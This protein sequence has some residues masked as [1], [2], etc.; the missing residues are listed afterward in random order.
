M[1]HI[2]IVIHVWEKMIMDNLKC[3]STLEDNGVILTCC[4]S[5][6]NHE[7]KGLWHRKG[8]VYW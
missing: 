8:R 2:V 7:E 6:P 3:I 4:R 5:D 1:V